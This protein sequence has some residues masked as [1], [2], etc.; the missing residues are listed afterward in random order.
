MTTI[1]EATSPGGGSVALYW[2]SDIGPEGR[3][4]IGVRPEDGAREFAAGVSRTDFLAAVAKEFDSEIVPNGEAVDARNRRE[5]ALY[6][7]DRFDTHTCKAVPKDAVVILRTEELAEW[8]FELLTTGEPITADQARQ[9][10]KNYA[11]IAQYLDENP[12]VDEAQVQ[13]LA[14]TIGSIGR[15]W[16]EISEGN[17]ARRLYL[18]GVRVTT[19]EDK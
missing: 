3:V 2:F 17:L 12:P 15:D 9:K 16:S 6:G 11:A 10:M 14:H 19:L 1:I 13:N 18:A 7:I 5:L 4:D 8:E